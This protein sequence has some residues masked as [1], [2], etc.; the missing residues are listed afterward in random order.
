MAG[1]RNEQNVLDRAIRVHRA[2]ESFI[3]ACDE[4]LWFEGDSAGHCKAI[5]RTM[6]KFE[7]IPAVYPHA[8]ELIH[9]VGEGSRREIGWL[10]DYA[11]PRLRACLEDVADHARELILETWGWEDGYTTETLRGLVRHRMRTGMPLHDRQYEE[12]LAI[13]KADFPGLRPEDIEGFPPFCET[14]P[15]EKRAQFDRIVESFDRTRR[16]FFNV[17][18]VTANPT[19]RESRISLDD[20]K[21]LLYANINNLDEMERSFCR[22]TSIDGD[23]P[24]PASESPLRKETR[25]YQESPLIGTRAATIHSRTFDSLLY[26]HYQLGKII[27]PSSEV[28]EPCPWEEPRAPVQE[29]VVGQFSAASVR[30]GTVC[31]TRLTAYPNEDPPKIVLDGSPYPVKYEAALYLDELI[32]ADGRPVSFKALQEVT[33]ALEGAVG[34]RLLGSLPPKILDLI[35]RGGKGSPVRLRVEL[36]K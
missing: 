21:Y 23:F 36:L 15:P 12:V 9:A 33:P 1:S 8:F 4:N 10:S 22:A 2:L 17:P 26:V 18:W 6:S 20:F 25:E 35:E 3:D 5:L 11:P 27:D 14:I 19:Y 28:D 34:T 13:F 29:G 7:G 30:P 32:Q 24:P 16:A 31:Q